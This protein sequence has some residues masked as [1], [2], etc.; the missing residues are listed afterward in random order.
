[1]QRLEVSGAVRLMYR[2]LGVKG[3]IVK[4]TPYGVLKTHVWCMKFLCIR[5]SLVFGTCLENKLWGYRSMRRQ[6]MRKVIHIFWPSSLLY[7]KTM[8]G[9]DAFSKMERSTILRKRQLS[10]RTLFRWSHCRACRWPPRSP[11][12]SLPDFFLC[13][14]LKETVYSN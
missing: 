2:S 13:G 14:F 1:M 7:C 6:L 11:D 5:Q 10:C 4:T 9:T 3:L 12:L 8:N